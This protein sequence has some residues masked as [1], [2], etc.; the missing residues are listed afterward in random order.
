[1]PDRRRRHMERRPAPQPRP[2]GEIDILQVHEEVAI[3]KA[4]VI[5]QRADDRPPPQPTAR[6]SAAVPSPPPQSASRPDPPAPGRSVDRDPRRGDPL[7]RVREEHR[8]HRRAERRVRFERRDQRLQPPRRSDR[9]V[10]QRDDDLVLTRQDPGVRPARQPQ[11]PPERQD[12]HAGIARLSSPTE[13][14]VEPLSTTMI[15]SACRVCHSSASRHAGSNPAPFQ[16]TITIATRIR[17]PHHRPT[18]R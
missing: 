18:G 10:V 8:G 13:P 16:L 17:L 5:E 2:P 4:N 12:A 11:V 6:R 7:R 14:S 9:V 1:M 3:E 15:S